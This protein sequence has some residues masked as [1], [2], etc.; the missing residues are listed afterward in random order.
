MRK[1]IFL[2]AWELVKKFGITLSRALTI[3]W[4]EYKIDSLYVKINALELKLNTADVREELKKLYAI[5]NPLT[6]ALNDIKP[7]IAYSNSMNGVAAW[8]D[9]KD[10]NN[11]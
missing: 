7:K 2:K 5:A 4:K 6:I 8:Y 11:D 1:S 9:G 3:S 10:F